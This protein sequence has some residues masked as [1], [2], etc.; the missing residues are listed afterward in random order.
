MM[1]GVYS[2][3]TIRAAESAAIAVVGDDALMQ[4]ASAGL[5]SVVAGEL[6]R[7]WGG[8][9]GRHLL[10][11]AGSGNNGG[12]ALFA[13]ARL[14]R[15]GVWVRAWRPGSGVHLAGWEAFLAAGGRELDAMAAL[16]ELP[17]TD[18]VL[19]GV[20][21]IGGQ[22]GLRAPVADF[23]R[24]CADGRVPV[25][26]VDLPSGLPA[27][28]PFVSLVPAGEQVDPVPVPVAARSTIGD[29]LA[30]HF[31][32]DVTVTFGGLKVCHVVE[33][34]RSAC[35]RIELVDIGLPAMEPELECWSPADVAAAWPVPSATS[36]KYSRGVVG[37]D[38]GSAKYPGAGVLAATGAVRAGAGMVRYLGPAEVAELV[39]SRLPNVVAGQGRVEAFVLGSGWGDRPDGPDV[40]AAAVV[41]GLPVV[42]DADA[43]G[44][45]P[46]R[47][48][49]QVLL[50]PHA[51]ELARLLGIAREQVTADPVAAVR[52]AVARTGA[53]VLL[54]GAT[55]LVATPGRSSVQVAVPGPGWTA[56]AGSGD[57]LAG[58][59]GALLAAGVAAPE[60]A[61][62]AASVQ[63]MS[64]PEAPLT[65]QDLVLTWH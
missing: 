29:G 61:G 22:A 10:I 14:A 11:V 32:A 23:A 47:L 2:V 58:I 52:H 45:L 3:A 44:M 18:L 20:T 51:G 56:Q 36:D 42:V 37:I 26:A 25:V 65:P 34:A 31:T 53:T 7:R 64:A 50:T 63:A 62:M 59:C 21:G 13:G 48:H 12:D 24:A 8:L 28:L 35:G 49:P 4:R 40:V 55:Q 1:H 33:P 16:A 15:R 9:Y 60:A 46:H 57:L 17:D 6:R 27:D 38:A 19:D 39:L 41:S 43:L 5:A 54:K 30:A